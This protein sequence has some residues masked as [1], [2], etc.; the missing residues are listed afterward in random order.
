MWSSVESCNKN[1]K[2]PVKKEVN[3]CTYTASGDMVCGVQTGRYGDSLILSKSNVSS[4]S[5]PAPKPKASGQNYREKFMN[6]SK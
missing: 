6:A 3:T 2:Q 5:L 4:S 1:K